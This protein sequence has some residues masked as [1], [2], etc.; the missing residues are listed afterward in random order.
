MI[1]V[2]LCDND[3]MI[4]PLVRT[5]DRGGVLRSGGGPEMSGTCRGHH[6]RNHRY[7]QEKTVTG[8]VYWCLQVHFCLV[9]D[10]LSVNS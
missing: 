4:D 6:D 8:M 5:G 7:C 2:E 10:C 3:C 1:G 9:S